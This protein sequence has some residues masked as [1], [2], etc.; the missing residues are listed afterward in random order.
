MQEIHWIN[1]CFIL[2]VYIVKSIDNL[3]N[4]L[5]YINKRMPD[6]VLKKE[7]LFIKRYIYNN[8]YRKYQRVLSMPTKNRMFVLDRYIYDLKSI[9]PSI[10]YNSK[11]P[12]DLLK[13]AKGDCEEVKKLQLITDNYKKIIEK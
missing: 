12:A 7:L 3:L 8:A 1:E 9:I 6:M 10:E 2:I 13:I 4:H 11:I 5:D